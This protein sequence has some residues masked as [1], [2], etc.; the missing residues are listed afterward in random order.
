MVDQICHLVV[1]SIKVWYR[2]NYAPPAAG[3]P[4]M[5]EEATQRILSSSPSTKAAK[6]P[7]GERIPGNRKGKEV[8]KRGNK[9]TNPAT[10]G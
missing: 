1:K 2:P 3:E 4:S 7:E 6:G 10:Q 5:L 9:A 8:D